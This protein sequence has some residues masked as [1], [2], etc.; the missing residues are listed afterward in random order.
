MHI[1]RLIV[2]AVGSC[3]LPDVEAILAVLV[4]ASGT[5]YVCEGASGCSSAHK[6]TM[7]KM[8]AAKRSQI[9]T[10]VLLLKAQCKH[11]LQRDLQRAQQQSTSAADMHERLTAAQQQLAA[12]TAERDKLQHET[13]AYANQCEDM[14]TAAKVKDEEVFVF[15]NRNLAAVD[16][17]RKAYTARGNQ[18]QQTAGL[19]MQLESCQA[20][21]AELRRRSAQ[22]SQEQAEHLNYMKIGC[23]AQ[24]CKHQAWCTE[25][26]AKCQGSRKDAE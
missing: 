4:Q 3:W 16:A 15:R 22:T 6:H 19:C 5:E 23:R 21:L 1:D 7:D 13:Q 14:R 10:A 17:V 11:D 24:R 20:E 12:V 26:C 2:A 25:E 8:A 18:E 9:A